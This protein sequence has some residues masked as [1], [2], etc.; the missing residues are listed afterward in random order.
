[1]NLNKQ[2]ILAA[3]DLVTEAVDVSE[4][5][6][7]VHVRTM[8]GLE[9]DNFE[10]SLLVGEGKN[11]QVDMT[12][13][14]ARL[15]CLCAVDEEGNRLFDD[16]DADALGKKSAAALDRVAEVA[17]RLNGMSEKDVGNIAKNSEAAPSGASTSGSV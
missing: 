4:W 15:V 16:G 10:K 6:G 7:T 8:N 1:M 14:R 12:N 9:R 5:G 17:R 13:M 2:T 11:R 3:Q